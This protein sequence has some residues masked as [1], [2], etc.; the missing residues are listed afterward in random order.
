MFDPV[1]LCAE[2]HLQ[3]FR[4]RFGRLHRRQKTRPTLE[5]KGTGAGRRRIDLVGKD[6]IS[7]KDQVHVEVKVT[8]VGSYILFGLFFPASI[9]TS[10]RLANHVA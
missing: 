8:D 10:R 5:G 9:Y 6:R 2:G 3:P 4:R 1:L 7:E